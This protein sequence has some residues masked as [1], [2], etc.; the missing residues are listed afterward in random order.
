MK[1][2]KLTDT[3]WQKL[4]DKYSILTA[5][6][7]KGYFKISSNE[8]KEFRE[9]RL[10]AKFDSSKYLPEVFKNNK[11][12]I[13]P[14]SRSK[15]I[16]GRFKL[17][18]NFPDLKNFNTKLPQIDLPELETIDIEKITSEANAI[19]VLQL[20]EILED[21]LELPENE[22]LY[23]TFNS[24]MGSGV[25]DF[26]VDTFDESRQFISVEN[27]QIEID[28]GFESED[29]VVIVEAKN[30]IHTD[31][32]VRQ[33]YYPFRKWSPLVNKPIRLVFSIY[34]NMIFRLLE[35][36]FEDINDYSSIKFIKE[37]YY[38][39]EDTTITIDDL[40][41]VFYST[42][43]EF[44][45]KIGKTEDSVPSVQADSFER[46]ISLL[47]NMYQNEMTKEDV[48]ELMHFS[49][50]Q[51]G[52]YF[53]AGRYLEIFCKKKNSDKQI[54][55]TLTEKGSEIYLSNYKKRQLLL[56]RQIFKHKVFRTLFE[57]VLTNGEL[58]EKDYITNLEL[59]YGMVNSR[60]TAERRARS[61]RAWISWIFNLTK[62]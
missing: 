7:N 36:E 31:F 14:I 35:Y 46:I 39:L 24:R 6:K 41:T 59:E 45:D 9:P 28:G 60:S 3:A 62:L 20:S 44:L 23:S 12:N 34:S 15:Y 11:L 53:N 21:F 1:Q 42:D 55:Y 13:L 54:V 33:L 4:I 38:S 56:V 19:N 37:K 43:C 2:Q 47:E 18:E 5:I 16:L 30:V 27:A 17:Y 48:Q 40:K 32:H 8:I 25:F 51:V 22:K 52:Y 49:E 61:I 58:P 26:F 50:R 10:M 57:N 29:F